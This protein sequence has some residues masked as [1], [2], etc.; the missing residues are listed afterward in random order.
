MLIGKIFMFGFKILSFKN[1][2]GI[3]ILCIE[4]YFLFFVSMWCCPVSLPPALHTSYF[5]HKCLAHLLP[6]S[7]SISTL[8]W[9]FQHCSQTQLPSTSSPQHFFDDTFEQI[10]QVIT[11][12]NDSFDHIMGPVLVSGWEYPLGDLAISWC[13]FCESISTL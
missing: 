6:L 1:N 13:S 11:L 4:F 8:L 3:T 2:H 5:K 7:L 12:D 10:P 9:W